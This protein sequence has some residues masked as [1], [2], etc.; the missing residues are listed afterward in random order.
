ME[1]SGKLYYS[2]SE[3]CEM[4]GLK[5][6][7]LRY[8]ESAFPMLN[9]SKNQ[10]GNRVYRSED[11]RLVRQ[12]SKLLYED[13]YTIDGARQKIQETIDSTDQMEL[14]LDGSG[15]LSETMAELKREIA[16]IIGMLE[17][18]PMA[19]DERPFTG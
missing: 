5:P 18:D 7:V 10:S 19:V 1:A 3:V 16:D 14:Q 2:I 17:R 11:I 6:H 13:L 8:W 12:I 15:A 4:T 9:P